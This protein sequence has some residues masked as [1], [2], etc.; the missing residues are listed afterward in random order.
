MS[1]ILHWIHFVTDGCHE[2]LAS[3]MIATLCWIP[4]FTDDCHTTLNSYLH[5]WMLHYNEFLH[6]LLIATV[7]RIPS[8]TDDC[9]IALNSYLHKCLQQCIEFL[10]SLVLRRISGVTDDCNTVLNSYL[11]WRIQHNI[12]G[13][14]SY[15]QRHFSVFSRLL[16][17]LLPIL[18]LSVGL[19]RMKIIPLGIKIHIIMIRWFWDCLI[20]IM[21]IPLPV[22]PHILILKQPREDCC[23]FDNVVNDAIP[24]M[25]N[26]F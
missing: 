23:C 5:G 4:T 24:I 25:L 6:S 2:F 11:H 8:F 14:Q 13:L 1:A 10:S 22:R 21:R 19:F 26:W 15:S 18:S 20:V 12:Q 17:V 16:C 7:F 3:L 9:H